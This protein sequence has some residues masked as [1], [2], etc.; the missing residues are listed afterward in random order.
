MVEESNA[1]QRGE[2]ADEIRILDL[3][4]VV[5]RQWR[6][7]LGAVVLSVVVAVG[8]HK[9]WPKY[10]TTHTVLLP[11]QDAGDS[12]SQLLLSQLSPALLGLGLAAGTSSSQA[13]IG[14][15]LR[16]ASLADSMVAR[17]GYE[18]HS[19][20]DQQVRYVLGKTKIRNGEGGS[21]VINVTSTSAQMAARI[22][23]EFPSLVNAM[24]V[25]LGTQT[26]IRKQDFLESQ[27]A[28]ARQRLENSEQ[29]LVQFQQAEDAPEVQEQ[30]RRTL[31]AAVRLQQQIMEQEIKVAQLRRVSTPDNPELQS[32]VAE[33]NGWRS[34]LSRLTAGQNT[35]TDVFFSLKESPELQLAATRLLREFKKDEQ[36]YLSLAAALVEAQVSAKNDLPVVSVLDHPEVPSGPTVY[37]TRIIAGMAALLGLCIGLIL[38]FGREYARSARL[39]PRNAGFFATWD[40]FTTELTSFLPHRWR[41]QARLPV[42]G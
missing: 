33:L 5:I 23:N 29:R 17:L 1:T 32:A 39:D 30:A 26:A 31:D 34:Q 2:S 7:I 8:A 20:G 19:K 35:R 16:S 21:V 9:V 3:V 11:S 28:Y 15:I 13:R 4:S 12:R 6:L 41:R 22:A 42:R 10:Y 14:V 37:P 25:H 38:A 24:V 36:V 40:Q 18:K 27:L